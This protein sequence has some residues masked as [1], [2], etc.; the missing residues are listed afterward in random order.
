MAPKDS[1]ASQISNADGDAQRPEDTPLETLVK[2]SKTTG[3]RKAPPSPHHH[4]A[5]D[6]MLHINRPHSPIKFDEKHHLKY[7]RP[8]TPPSPHHYDSPEKMVKPMAV[9]YTSEKKVTFKYVLVGTIHV[10]PAELFFGNYSVTG[11][12]NTLVDGI[13]SAEVSVCVN[14]PLLSEEQ[15]LSLNPMSITV[16][17]ID[18][19]PNRPT[20]FAE[21]EERCHPLYTKFCFYDD[22]HVRE[23]HPKTKRAHKFPISTRHLLLAGL[24]DEDSLRE[25]LLNKKFVVEVHDRDL[26]LP[27]DLSKVANSMSK[28][29]AIN[30]GSFD[31]PPPF[32]VAEFCKCFGLYRVFF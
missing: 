21:L 19:L 22:P 30:S 13:T 9:K 24:L 26:K 15:E 4:D 10:D 29:G 16:I 27:T 28:S 20:P 14:N 23:A 3:R 18:G 31:L 2:S 17:G 32:G 6:K 5:P 12:L 7:I 11:K 25:N 8:K 1:N